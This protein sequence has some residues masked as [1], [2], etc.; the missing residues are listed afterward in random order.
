MS[1]YDADAIVEQ[2]IYDTLVSY[3]PLVDIVGNNDD[4]NVPQVYRGVAPQSEGVHPPYVIFHNQTLGGTNIIALMSGGKIVA[5]E[6][7]YV[8]KVV[9]LSSQG[10]EVSRANKAVRDALH[11]KSYQSVLDGT[12]LVCVQERTYV[13][14]PEIIEGVVYETRGGLYRILSQEEE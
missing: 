6:S 1:V 11:G 2:W 14:P 13:F 10:D 4:F 12:V 9:G 8:V 3:T 5:N 7:L